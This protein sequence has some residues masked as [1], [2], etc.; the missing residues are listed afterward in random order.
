[1]NLTYNLGTPFLI[2]KI[3]VISY[4]YFIIIM[5]VITKYTVKKKIFFFFNSCV[6]VYFVLFLL[7]VLVN[8]TSKYIQSTYYLNFSSST[9]TPKQ[10]LFMSQL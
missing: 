1:M 8:C 5:Y 4:L 3:N 2:N 6:H 9:L 10:L 7:R